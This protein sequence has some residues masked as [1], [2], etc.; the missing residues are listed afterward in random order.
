MAEDRVT[1]PLAAVKVAASLLCN[2]ICPDPQ[3]D[4]VLA[5]GHD[6]ICLMAILTDAENAAAAVYAATSISQDCLKGEHPLCKGCA[7]HHH[8]LKTGRMRK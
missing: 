5:G 1:L 4:E 3:T 6:P 2:V 8:E 7:C